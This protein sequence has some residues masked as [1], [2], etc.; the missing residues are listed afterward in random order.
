M[1]GGGGGVPTGAPMLKS[2]SAQV[3]RV[4]VENEN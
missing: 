3:P 2:E 4:K 1:G